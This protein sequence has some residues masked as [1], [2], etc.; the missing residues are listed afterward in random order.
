MA[1]T[2]DGGSGHWQAEDGKPE[3]RAVLVPPQ[4]GYST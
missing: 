1:S 4:R 2:Q 3:L